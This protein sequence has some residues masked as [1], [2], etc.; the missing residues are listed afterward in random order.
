MHVQAI[1]FDLDGTLYIQR[2][3]RFI[4]LRQ[5]LI[6]SLRKPA[7]ALQT[8]QIVRAYRKAQEAL[9]ATSEPC[10]IAQAQIDLTCRL[11]GLE[12]EQVTCCATTW[13]DQ[14]PLL[15]LRRYMRPGL[16]EFLQAAKD[17]GIKLAVLSDYPAESKLEAMEIRHLFDLVVS[18]QDMAIGCFKP[19]PAGLEFVAR[20]LG[21]EKSR[22][23]YV[24]DR[25]EVDGEAARRAGIP[26]AIIGNYKPRRDSTFMQVRTYP[27]LSLALGL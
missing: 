16:G 7:Q 10:D 6:Q 25:P 1:C 4:M 18:A 11:T 22:M 15:F 8:F 23:L 26:A 20:E 2:P 14:A 24:G 12:R 19:S 5:L 3:L 27:E 9:R 17:R 21:I 13:F